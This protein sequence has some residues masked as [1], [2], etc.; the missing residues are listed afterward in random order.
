MPE[1]RRHAK[2]PADRPRLSPLAQPLREQAG[3]R[4]KPIDFARKPV[5][6]WRRR[7]P[8]GR[9]WPGCPA[10]RGSR[11]LGE[12]ASVRQVRVE[13]RARVG[14][15]PKSN[16]V[17]LP[18]GVAQADN[19]KGAAA[20]TRSRN[21]HRISAPAPAAQS[22]ARPEPGAGG[23]RPNSR[24]WGCCSTS[25]STRSRV[26]EVREKSSSAPDNRGRGVAHDLRLQRSAR[27][28]QPPAPPRPTSSS[29][30]RCWRKSTVTDPMSRISR[31][32][33]SNRGAGLGFQTL[34]A[35]WPPA[36]DR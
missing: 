8:G 14:G 26:R 22:R 29:A 25:W 11:D 5:P 16:R 7:R 24:L 36:A 20:A 1:F 4:R 6:G 13:R 2:T 23:L 27:C 33:C 12:R 31:S 32:S 35:T 3:R 21:P 10:E 9:R 18:P 19:S 30:A 34:Q 15:G 17:T 28:A